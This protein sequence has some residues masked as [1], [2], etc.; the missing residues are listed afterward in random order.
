MYVGVRDH[1][2]NSVNIQA[3]ARFSFIP[4]SLGYT[5]M[6]VEKAIN[7]VTEM[8]ARVIERRGDIAI[9]HMSFQLVLQS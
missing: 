1:M 3:S 2:C 9:V 8:I 5:C 7:E 6:E 4:G